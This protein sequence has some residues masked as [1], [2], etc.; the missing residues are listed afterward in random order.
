M[1]RSFFLSAACVALCGLSA[2]DKVSVEGGVSASGLVQSQSLIS[3]VKPELSPV[4]EPS[5]ATLLSEP[6]VAGSVL[7][8]QHGFSTKARLRAVLVDASNTPKTFELLNDRD[9]VV[10]SGQTV[11]FGAD[12]ASDLSVHQIDAPL[13]GHVGTGFTVR[14][15][16]IKSDPFDI[17][18]RPYASLSRDSL[19]YFYQSRV[20][21]PVEAIYVPSATPPLTRPAGH[22]DRT[23]TCFSG[24]DD[25]GTDWPGCDYSLS[26]TGGWYDAGD[27]GQYAVNTGFTTWMLLNMA[28]R[29]KS[30][31][32]RQCA[33]ELG[34]M[35]LHLPEAGNGVSD[36]LDEAR[37]GVEYL[38]STQT[39]S[40]T[41]QAMARGNQ[42]ATGPL[43]LTLTSPTGM[44]HHKS[45]GIS[46]P[47]DD[48]LPHTDA[49][50]R[51]LYPPTTSATL[52]LAAIGAQCA[53]L[54]ASVD[55]AF[56]AQCL[57]AARTAYASA[58]RVPDAYAWGEFDG[59]GPYDDRTLTDEFGWAATELWLTTQEAGF[60]GD[61]DRYVPAYN[62]FGS[63]SWSAVEGL[64]ML[65]LM[66]SERSIAGQT[67]LNAART[68]LLTWAD[69]YESQTGEAGFMVPKSGLDYYWGSNGD[70]MNRAIIMGT[71][72][73]STGDD[74]YRRG[75]TDAMDYVLGRNPLGRS[76]VT[77]YGERP[78]RNPHHRFWRGGSDAT[79]PF[80]PPGA[81]SGGPN[82]INFID[83]IGST[84]RGQCTSMTC[85][86]DE[87]AAYSLNEV[88]I[89]WNAG[90]AWTAH[91]LDRQ[92]ASCAAP[93][94]PS[95]GVE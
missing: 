5:S 84:L 29:R 25:R 59:G 88:A 48:V 6:A 10:L 42:A 93:P 69:R 4:A 92:D 8:N 51:R 30:G 81:L 77:G 44:V 47:G 62:P 76:Y 91:W 57:S 41:P 79:L 24:T 19:S 63:F 71:A 20:G 80:P 34:D 78:A 23:L 83:P 18:G 49:I 56:S 12:P 39:S 85:W 40:T 21:E 52:H 11:P 90:L 64:G 58:S 53:R 38:L 32:V 70:F 46:W 94:R 2:C 43:S 33:P 75:V 66:A 60:A 86:A 87:Y 3:P 54:F 37:R 28:E 16:G 7:L 35:S 9:Q 95:D 74:K 82:N 89:N 26:V 13:T 27:Y 45:H 61:M 14:V 17:G 31:S 1:R 55:K 73:T 50:T 22:V 68:A 67:R 36:I 15:E 65:S 72:H